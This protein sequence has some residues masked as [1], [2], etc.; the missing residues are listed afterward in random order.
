MASPRPR[1]DRIVS[2][3][4]L[5]LLGLAVV[6]F[7]DIN[8]NILRARLGGDLPVITISWLLIASLVVITSTGADVFIRTHPEMQTR[9]LP[10]IRIGPV[11]F[12]LV[13]EFWILPSFAIIASFAFFRLFSASLDALA[14]IIALVAAGALLFAALIGQHY[15]LDRR[16]ATQ[17]SAR[18]V[19][20]AIT[21]F[22]AFAVFSAVYYAR[23]RTLYS[24]ALI[25]TTGTLL[26]YALLHWSRARTR[27]FL[28]CGTVG[29][30]LAEATWALNYWSASFLIGGALL[31]VI[32]YV[33]IGLLQSYLEQRMHGRVLL[34]YSLLG[35]VL[36]ALLVYVTFR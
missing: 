19:L 35:S 6:F 25:G 24:A 27:P 32:F 23:L 2:L 16:P 10:A 12:E 20:Q 34:E 22:L 26:A 30:M 9:A 7:I 28:L 5:V 11:A 36:L 18:L 31:L 17:Q 8:P 14:F 1:Y 15:G 4:L 29:L 13:P 33:V 3:V 21:L